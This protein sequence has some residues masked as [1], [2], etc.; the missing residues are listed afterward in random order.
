MYHN[1]AVVVYKFTFNRFC[2]KSR[3]HLLEIEIL[4]AK[5]LNAF[6]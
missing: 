6:V 4:F 2:P 1:R 5:Q 3:S